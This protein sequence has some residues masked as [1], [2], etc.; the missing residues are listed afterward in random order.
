MPG[1]SVWNGGAARTGTASI[2]AVSA[3]TR[4][5]LESP[6]GCIDDAATRRRDPIIPTAWRSKLVGAL[7]QPV[8]E[9]RRELEGLVFLEPAFRY[10]LRQEAAID[11]PGNV[12]TRR[13]REER[14]RVVVESDGV[15]EPCRL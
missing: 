9:L 5:P 7:D 8:P 1:S 15:V 10:E 13:D 11:A 2:A 6:R 3:S 14:A 12:V 4:C